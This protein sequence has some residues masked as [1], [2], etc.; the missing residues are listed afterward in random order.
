MLVLVV[1]CLVVGGVR[2]P[3]RWRAP[4]GWWRY[5]D[6]SFFRARRMFGGERRE[7][8]LLFWSTVVVCGVVAED[9]WSRD[10]CVDGYGYGCPTSIIASQMRAECQPR[11][12]DI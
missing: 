3:V 11:K 8:G 5:V 4:C 7:G 10:F 1:E 2:R 12:T 9:V 6:L